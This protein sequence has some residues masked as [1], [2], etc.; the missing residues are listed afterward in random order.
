MYLKEIKGHK[1]ESPRLSQTNE[2]PPMRESKTEKKVRILSF[3]SL[4]IASNKRS[5]RVTR[6]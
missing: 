3:N 4:F 2:A 5:K 1:L 6:I